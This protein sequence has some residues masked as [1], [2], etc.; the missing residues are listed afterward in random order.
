M[1]RRPPTRTLSPPHPRPNSPTSGLRSSKGANRRNP[2]HACT[3]RGGAPW[4]IPRRIHRGHKERRRNNNLRL[5]D[6]RM[7]HCV[8]RRGLR[9]KEYRSRGGGE[10]GRGPTDQRRACRRRSTANNE[11]LESARIQMVKARRAIRGG[12]PTGRTHRR[13]RHDYDVVQSRITS[14]TLRH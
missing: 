12:E 13:P 5:N 7:T 9:V 14:D 8:G 6:K 4:Q 1:E 10:E 11:R 2:R 3:P